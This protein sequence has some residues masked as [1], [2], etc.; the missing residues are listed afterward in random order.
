MPVKL[1]LAKC[2]VFQGSWPSAEDYY[3]Y[4]YAAGNAP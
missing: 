2:T 3:D 4:Y 1:W